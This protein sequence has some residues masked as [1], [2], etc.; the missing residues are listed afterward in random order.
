M[1]HDGQHF[2]ALPHRA[3]RLLIQPRVLQGERRQSGELIAH[4]Q[5]VDGVRRAGPGA[6][7]VERADGAPPRT[8]RHEQHRTRAQ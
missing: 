5:F 2:V 3:S 8:Q 7:E 4:M 1:R 6:H